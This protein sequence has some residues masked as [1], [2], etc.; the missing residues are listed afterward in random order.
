MKAT[1]FKKKIFDFSDQLYPMVYRLLGSRYQTEDAI[2]D[3]MM[4]LWIKRHKIKTH[5]NLKG[6]IILTA[7]NHCID[8]LRK[9][10][11]VVQVNEEFTKDEKTDNEHSNVEWNQLKCVINT[12][13]EKVPKQQKEVFLMKDI[14]GYAYKEIAFA[15]DINVEHCRVLS[16]RV[17]QFIAKELE[18]TYH[19][20][21]G[22][23]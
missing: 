12:I 6:L 11:K 18:T 20:E 15:L 21:R 7:R 22:T 2:Q 10:I 16:S 4:K 14:D 5:P 19:Y 13:L 9:N 17:R 8:R 23:Y 1:E 3:I